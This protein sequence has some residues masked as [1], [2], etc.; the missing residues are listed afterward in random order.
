MSHARDNSYIS[1]LYYG[2]TFV[3][4]NKTSNNVYIGNIL[5]FI[6]VLLFLCSLLMI[7][8][9]VVHG[10]QMNVA[11][12]RDGHSRYVFFGSWYIHY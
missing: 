6:T 11:S 4:K 3:C 2:E 12:P 7:I 8:L 1:G 9:A 10:L 5:N